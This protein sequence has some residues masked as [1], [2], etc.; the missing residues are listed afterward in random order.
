MSLE[1]KIYKEKSVCLLGCGSSLDDKRIDF[2]KY[3]KIVGINRIYKTR[4]LYHLDILYDSAHYKHDPLNEIKVNILNKSKLEYYFL[5]PGIKSFEKLKMQKKLL[6]KIKIKNSLYKNRHDMKIN[7]KKILAGLY[8]L[9]IIMTGEPKEIEIYGFDF[10]EKGYT[11]SLSYAHNIETIKKMH[12]IN[13]EK[14]YFEEL[15]KKNNLI[16]WVK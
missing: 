6:D 5:T 12:D 10:Y 7:G 15:I 11:S 8:V 3:D 9:N 2:K 13:E 14:K 1:K 4:Y 16:K